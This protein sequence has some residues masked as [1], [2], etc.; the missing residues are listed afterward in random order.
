MDSQPAA[1]LRRFNPFCAQALEAAAQAKIQPDHWLLNLLQQRARGTLS[2]SLTRDT[3]E[4]GEVSFT[5]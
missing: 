4:A 2:N 1:L 5:F 3:N